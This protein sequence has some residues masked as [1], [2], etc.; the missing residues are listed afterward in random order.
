M[1]LAGGVKRWRCPPSVS[2]SDASREQYTHGESWR[3]GHLSVNRWLETDVCGL[4]T[5][6]QALF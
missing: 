2:L 1:W 6:P 4:R 3:F 5:D